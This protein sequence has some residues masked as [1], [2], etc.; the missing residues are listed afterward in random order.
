MR[1][2]T[3]ESDKNQA[4]LVLI[5]SLSLIIM[6]PIL[7]FIGCVAR[8]YILSKLWGWYVVPFFSTPPISL[9]TAFGLSLIV[10]YLIP[11]NHA[12][13]E[14]SDSEK[15]IASTFIPVIVLFLGYIGT[16]FM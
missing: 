5:G 4:K 3:S 11:F 9:V 12:K 15:L 14:R 7:I 6:C 10:T 2:T 13:D 8:A 1:I 16:W